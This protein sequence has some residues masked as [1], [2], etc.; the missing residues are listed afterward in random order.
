MELLITPYVHSKDTPDLQAKIDEVRSF[1][2]NN[3]LAIKAEIE[4]GP[5]DWEKELSSP[6]CWRERGSLNASFSTTWGSIT[7]PDPWGAGTGTLDAVLDELPIQ[8]SF[9]SSMAGIDPNPEGQRQPLIQV[10]ASVP[11]PAGD[12]LLAALVP[13]NDPELIAPGGIV[14]LDIREGFGILFRQFWQ[15]GTIQTEIFMLLDGALTFQDASMTT[16]APVV[17]TIEAN[18][19]ESG[20]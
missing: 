19:R 11:D 5:V 17:G 14:T 2:L 7:S 1:V 15:E 20:W 4:S 10:L 6:P 16:G 8:V 3:P 9:V 12:L 13:I 18:I